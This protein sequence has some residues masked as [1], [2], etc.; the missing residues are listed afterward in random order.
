MNYYLVVHDVPSFQ[1]HEDWIGKAGKKA[2]ADF[3]ALQR[4]D[5]IVYYCK[6]DLVIT[7]TFKVASAPRIVL[8]D[9][10]WKGPHVVVTIKPVAKAEAPFYVPVRR[11]LEELPEPLSIFPNR[12][13]SGIR[14]RGKTFVAITKQDFHAITKYVRTYKPKA[15]P[16]RGK[17]NDAGLGEPRDFGVMYY[18]PTSEQGVVA[19]FVGH[20]KALGFEKLEFIRQGFP[21]ACAIKRTGTTYERKFIEFEYKSSGFRQHVNNPKHRDYRCD[22]VVCWEHNYPTCPV[23]VIELRSAMDRILGS[24]Q[25]AEEATPEPAAPPAVTKPKAKPEKKP[26]KAKKAKEPAKPRTK[27]PKQSGVTVAD[28]LAQGK[29]KPG[30]EMRLDWKGKQFTATIQADGTIL[31]DGEVYASP[32]SAGKAARKGMSTNGWRYWKVLV[33]EEWVQLGSLRK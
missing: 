7:G 6:E 5:G 20:M 25:P 28:L 15:L 17:S 4:G 16:F 1:Q 2:P 18:A 8:D 14:L 11:M 30:Q 26:A 24:G 12:K 10:A 9:E 13:L 29:L 31:F 21:D 3:A 27:S 22:Y 23:E 19:L 33:G 32:S